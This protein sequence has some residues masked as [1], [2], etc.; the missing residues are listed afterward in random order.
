MP[1]PYGPEAIA[2]LVKLLKSR[3]GNVKIAAAR[4]LLDRGYGKAPQAQPT[5]AN[6]RGITIQ[7]VRY[8]DLERDCLLDGLSSQLSYHSVCCAE[9]LPGLAQSIIEMGGWS[10]QIMP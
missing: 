2:V 5:E 6:E 8:S 4:E 7:L 10:N 9:I 3:Y 1:R